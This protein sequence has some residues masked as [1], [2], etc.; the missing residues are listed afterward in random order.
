[1]S[2]LPRL[3][4]SML[5]VGVFAGCASSNAGERTQRQTAAAENMKLGV[6]YLQRGQYQDAKDKLDRAVELDPKNFEVHWAMASLWEHIA[7][8]KEAEASYKKAMKLSP[9][10]PEITNTYAVFLCKSGKVDQA[11]PLFDAVL[12]NKLYP[13]PWVVATNAAVCL[14]SDKR[15]SDAL[16]YLDRALTMRRDY[17]EAAIQ[18]A[19]LQLA[20]GRAAQAKLNVDAWLGQ[21]RKS[22]DLLLIGVRAA[23]ALDDRA[24]VDNY[25]R[26]LRRDFPNSSQAQALPQIVSGTK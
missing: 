17:L 12:K 15:N 13:T 3:M 19:D 4:L 26:L 24:A 8:P 9:N 16:A 22:A 14:R 10:N 25:S 21:Q 5:L 18:M 1:M 6:A 20:L 2:K 7:M 11:Q 23:V